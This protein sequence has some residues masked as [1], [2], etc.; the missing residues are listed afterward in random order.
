MISVQS[1]KPTVAQAKEAARWLA[2][3]G[4]I[5]PIFLVVAFTVA[6]I[7]RPGYSPIRQAISDLGVGPNGWLMDSSAVINGLLLIA[8]AAGFSIG[9]RKTLSPVWCWSSAIL[10]ALPGCDFAIAGIF[11][12]APATLAIHWMV[13]ANLLFIGP[14]IAFLVAGLALRR[15]AEWRNWGTALLIAC[16]V[17]AVVI[18]VTF[19]SFAPDTTVMSTRVSGLMERL[20][21]IEIEAWYAALGWQLFRVRPTGMLAS[22]RERVL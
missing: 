22:S 19:W 6:G 11:T 7:L 9:M 2:L 13:G 3:A 17:T 14:M 15:T 1:A 12:E 16:A 21:V 8:F 20:A 18:A 10:L 5:A 4:V